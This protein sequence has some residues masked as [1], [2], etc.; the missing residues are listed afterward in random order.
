MVAD[1]MEIE[2][3]TLEIDETGKVI[4][5]AYIPLENGYTVSFHVHSYDYDN[6]NKTNHVPMVVLS[7]KNGKI[8]SEPSCYDSKNAQKAI[9]RAKQTAINTAENYKEYI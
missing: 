8:I 6:G 3:N 2:D 5:S 4:G 1:K 9:E 7:D